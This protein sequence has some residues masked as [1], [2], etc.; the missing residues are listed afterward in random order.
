MIDQKP[1]DAPQ[2][3]EQANDAALCGAGAGLSPRKLAACGV[4]TMI[5]PQ[6][7]AIWRIPAERAG[8]AFLAFLDGRKAMLDAEIGPIQLLFHRQLDR[9]LT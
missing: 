8:L 6:K 1:P 2:G 3:G 9:G 4:T 7:P 5:D